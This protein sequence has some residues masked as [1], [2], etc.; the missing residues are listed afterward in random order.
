[1]TILVLLAEATTEPTTTALFA[2]VM[3]VAGETLPLLLVA[4]LPAKF[5]AQEAGGLLC[6]CLT[7]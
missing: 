1:M 3:L 7:Q 6:L 4:M 5:Q 2:T